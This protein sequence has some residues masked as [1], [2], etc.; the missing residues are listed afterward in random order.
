MVTGMAMAGGYYIPVFVELCTLRQI[1]MYLTPNMTVRVGL[2][3]KESRTSYLLRSS[4]VQYCT[5]CTRASM[6]LV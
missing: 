6:G 1:N 3:S 2:F 4:Y 5:P